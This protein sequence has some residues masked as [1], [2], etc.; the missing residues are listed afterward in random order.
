M[1][2]SR[3]NSPSKASS[4]ARC[5]SHLCDPEAANIRRF[6]HDAVAEARVE[7]AQGRERKL[8]EVDAFGEFPTRDRWI[9]NIGHELRMTCLERNEFLSARGVLVA[10]QNEQFLLLAL[11]AKIQ[12]AD[13]Q[14]GEF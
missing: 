7:L 4:E 5:P 14:I 9:A 8:A 3:A 2:T 13:F 6:A 12:R 11:A 10:D 1:R